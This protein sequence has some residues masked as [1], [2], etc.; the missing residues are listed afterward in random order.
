MPSVD[1]A[2]THIAVAIVDEGFVEAR[3][4][5]CDVT[6]VDNVHVACGHILR[7]STL[8]VPEA[9]LHTRPSL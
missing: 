3:Q 1:R 6:K 7:N 2:R 4:R 5:G 9:R 8:Y